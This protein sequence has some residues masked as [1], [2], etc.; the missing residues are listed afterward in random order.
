MDYDARLDHIIAQIRN[1][2]DKQAQRELL[3]MSR[4]VEKVL[5][6]LDKELVTCRRLH[7]TTTHYQTLH[8]QAAELLSNLE[9]LLTFAQLKYG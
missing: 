8:D 2:N 7:K 9:Q 3:L 4:T 6:E 5:T 1:V